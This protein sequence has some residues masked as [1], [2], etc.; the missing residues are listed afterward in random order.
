M[1][2]ARIPSPH[3]KS[4]HLSKK[5]SEF[6]DETAKT[7]LTS[8]KTPKYLDEWK[9]AP[10]YVANC[11]ITCH[12]ERTYRALWGRPGW[13]VRPNRRNGHGKRPWRPVRAG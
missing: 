13:Q 5:N 7:M 12:M 8:K 10:A 9:V 2:P 11:K 4:T 3:T 6:L 1:N